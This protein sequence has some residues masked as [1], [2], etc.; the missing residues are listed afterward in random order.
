[1][2]G[3]DILYFPIDTNR[4]MKDGTEDLQV[5]YERLAL[6]DATWTKPQRTTEYQSMDETDLTCNL[7]LGS[8]QSQLA[9]I[10]FYKT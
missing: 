7:F 4:G 2:D 8:F 9:M 1:L 3:V 10:D 5:V 6:R